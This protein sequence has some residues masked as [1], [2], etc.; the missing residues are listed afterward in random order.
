[1][2]VPQTFGG[3]FS[4][5]NYVCNAYLWLLVG[6]LFRLPDLLAHSVA[7]AVVSEPRRGTRGSFQF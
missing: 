2:L 6:M 5:Q 4:Y 3:L 7:P 1:L